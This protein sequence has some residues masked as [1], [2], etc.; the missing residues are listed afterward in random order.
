MSSPVKL[1]GP[2]SQMTIAWSISA[3]EPAHKRRTTACRGVGK[4]RQV[5]VSN[6]CPAAGPEIRKIATAA[7]SGAVDSAKIVSLILSL[8]S[9]D[10]S[11]CP[12]HELQP[13]FGQVT[14][15][16]TVIGDKL[17]HG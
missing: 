4:G 12:I 17:R 1:P 11:S 13:R 14:C 8:M 15:L 10:D 16:T 7:R 3:C 9:P 6:A 2:G 5:K